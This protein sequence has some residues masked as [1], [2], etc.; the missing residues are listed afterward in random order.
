MSKLGRFVVLGLFAFGCDVPGP[1][2]APVFDSQ[3]EAVLG[4]ACVD[5]TDCGG[6]EYCHFQVSDACGESDEGSCSAKPKFCPL[7]YAPVCGCDGETYPNS[8]WAKKN[9]TTAAYFG[10]CPITV[11]GGFTDVECEEDEYCHYQNEL[12]CNVTEFTGV[13]K[14]RPHLCP[15]VYAPVCGCDGET[16]P[17][18]CVARASGTSVFVDGACDEDMTLCQGNVDCGKGEY[19]H[20]DEATCTLGGTMGICKPR[21]VQCP[22]V[23]DPVCGCDFE[24]YGNACAAAAAGVSVFKPDAC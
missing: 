11:C 22:L 16:Y 5:K 14:K 21:P 9:G 20:W 23:Y 6:G 13:C 4:A 17:N 3:S 7:N 19:C 12:T 2:A 24:T 10:E 15:Y 8:C 1:E 18:A